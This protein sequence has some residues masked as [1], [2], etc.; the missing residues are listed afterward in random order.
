MDIPAQFEGSAPSALDDS[1]LCQRSCGGFVACALF[2]LL[3]M[4]VILSFLLALIW[5]ASFV[6]C[7][8]QDSL[9]MWRTF[10]LHTPISPG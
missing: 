2:V 6:S 8:F 10:T 9:M 3:F 7:L 5:C 1:N 4:F